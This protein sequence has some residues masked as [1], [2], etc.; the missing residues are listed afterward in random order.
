M[1]FPYYTQLDAMDCGPTS[2]R[3][4]A[5]FY[6]RHYS[7]QNLRERC[8]ITREGVSLLGISDAAESIGFRT[9]GV[10][11]TWHQ[12]RDEANLP[13]IVHW[14]QQ[15]FVVVYR[16]ARK[17]GKWWVYVSDPA[18][19]LL[20]YTEEQFLKAW[21]QSREL[22][23]RTESA[24]RPQQE[25]PSLASADFLAG[26]ANGKGIALLL[27]PTP[28]FYKEKGDEDKRLKLGYLLQYLRPYKNY[29]AQL[30]LAMLTA[31]ILSLILPFL[32]QSVVDKG[33][34]TGNLS[35][36]VMMLIAQVVLVLGQLANNLIRS[37][38]MLHMTTRI[39]ISLISDFLA[40]LMRLP[41]AF[42]DSKMVGD[43]MQ[44]IGDYDRIQ[45]FLTGSL[46]SMAMA[47]VSFVIYGAVMGGYDP[48]ILGIFL[49]GSALYIGWILLFMKRRRKLDYMRFQEAAANQSNIVQLIDGMQEIKLNDCEKQKRWE[50]ERIQARLFQVSIK[51]LVLGQTQEV[52]GTFIDQT[53]NVVISF[54]AASAVIEGDMT[55]GMMVALQYIIG[56][57]NA[58]LSQFIQF[59]QATQDAKIS[60]ERL[61]EIQEKDDEEPAD[62]ERIRMI[63]DNAD[64][65]FR[66]VTFQYDGPHSAKALDDVSVTIPAD[67]VTAIVGASGSGKTTMLK[68]MLGFYT[69]TSGEVLLHD[70]RIAQY[71]P[72][73]WRR[74][75]GTVMQEGY[76]FSDT[77]AGNIGVSDER[78]DMER[79]RRATRIANI[80]TFIDELPL[81]Y[82]TKIG[83]DGHGLS[84]GQKQRL[85]IARAAY[86]DAKY[87]FFDEAT[88]SLDANNERTIMERLD[89]LFE[90]KTVVVVAHRLSTV[91]NADKIVVLDRGRI[92]EQGTH[93]ELTAKKGYYYELVRNQLEL[94]N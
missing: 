84:V 87:L 74:A 41:I 14:N 37:W 2:L 92:V 62:E 57:L 28:Q 51:G 11:I 34:G 60:L 81:G 76:I 8:H 44:R 45:S 26:P 59:V 78:P 82:N 61:S 50:W 43:I 79:V 21:I 32:T 4:V 94:G 6:G 7:L 75:C 3:I 40:K 31:S 15:H 29:L 90:N 77:I 71:S 86:K 1:S 13:C 55:L 18:S 67:K 91:R 22:P 63:P 49:L 36:V 46:L 54:L 19:G 89:R 42:F 27:E 65:E 35:F 56:Q 17:R 48:T 64:I 88:N 70:R 83:A 52:G 69:P 16:I 93:E 80:D 72:S 68:L 9:T 85:L 66:G 58:P 38:L 12:L 73:C 23:N 20:K 5:Q 33:I 30:A 53:K 25:V 47:V 24:A 39:S 10:K